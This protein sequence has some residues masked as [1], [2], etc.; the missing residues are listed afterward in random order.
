[1]QMAEGDVPQD[2]TIA[3]GNRTEGLVVVADVAAG[4]TYASYQNAIPVIRSILVENSSGL[5][6]ETCRLELTS[7]PAFLRPKTWTIDRLAPGDSLT[8]SD[9]KVELDAGYLAGL[10]EAERGEITL[11]LVT[12]GEV[13]HEQRI[14]V[15]LVARDEW[16]GVADMAQLL[17]AFVMPNDPAVAAILRAAADRLAAHGHQ[18][19]LDGYQSGSPQRAFL[20]AAAVYSAIAG[21]GLH[22][23]EPPA[24]FERRGQKVRR[25]GTILDERLA[26]CLDTTLL[27]AAALEAAGLNP[28]VL[29]FEGHAAVGVWLAKRTFPSA[30]EPDAMEV[31]K[32]LALRE[33]IVFETT[34][35]THRPA[36]T[37]EAAQQ[38]LDRRIGDDDA[39]AFLAAIDVRRARS[40][41]ITPLASHAP[42]Q[43]GA[44]DD[45]APVA[46][47]PLPA[48]P[49]F[50]DLPAEPAE[51]KPTT[52]AGR[53]DRW[54]KKLLDL[55]L[56]NRLLN[57][58]DS[59]KSIPFLCTDVG[60]LEDRLAK[61][62]AIRVISLPEQNPLGERDP[63][64][65]RD[66]HGRDLQRGFV[67]EALQRDELPSPLEPRQLEARL[68]ELH[69]QVRNDFAEGGANTLFLAVGFLRWK[70]KP[71]DERSY[72]APLLL[73]PVKLERRSA[74]SRFTIRFHEDEPRFNATLLQFLDREFDLKLTS[75]GGEL[76]TDDNGVDVPKLLGQVRQAIRDV[77]GME[78][79][80]ETALSTFSFAKFLMWKDLVERTDALRQNRV[81]RHLIDTP[82]QAFA[83]PEGAAPFREGYEIDRAYAP[84]DIICL[85]PSDSSQTAASLAAA[86]GRDFVIVG[87]PG[88]GKS[89][90][91]ANMIANCLGVGKTVL[92]VAEKTAALDVVNR[93]LREHGLG[94]QC[95]ELH[96]NKADRKHFL[97]QLKAA[98]E[99]G[100]T[101]DASAWVA[102][103]ERLR[104]RRD[105]LNAYVEALH[106]RYPNGW[107][108][109]L[110]LGR[111][112]KDAGQ[113][114]PQLGW[115]DGRA[116][117]EA[118]LRELEDLAAELGLVF[119]SVD[120]QPALDLVDQEEW[121][122]SW[123]EALLGAAQSL[124]NAADLLA[125]AAE[126]L[127]GVLGLTPQDR[128]APV[129][130]AALAGLAEALAAARGRDISVA[131]NRDFATSAAE[132]AELES[133]IGV[134]RAT[135]R[136]LAAGYGIAAVRAL[137]IDALE[138][139]WRAANDSFWPMSIFARR[140]ARQLLQAEAA[141]GEVDPDRDLPL[142]RRM[143][144]CLAAI[145]A[146]PLGTKP[147]PIRGL[148]T[149]IAAVAAL[150]ALAEG[151]RTALRAPGWGQEGVGA[152]IRA[153]A[154]CLPG[155]AEPDRVRAAGDRLLACLRG[156]E[157]ASRGFGDLAG[158]EVAACATGAE[159]A[160][161]G[162]TL[163]ELIAARALLRDWTAWCRVR[164]AALGR[165]LG[166]LVDA[167][168]DGTI[169]PDAARAAFRLGYA[170]WWLPQ[171][172]DGDPVLRDFR[173]F[174]HENAIKDFRE[175]DDLVRTHATGRVLSA[176]AHG[177]PPVQGVPRNSEL[178]LLR[179]QMELQR[180]SQTI[181]DMIGRM[182]QSFP[183]L[184]PCMLM[185]PL[186]IAQYLPSNQAL[187]DVVIFDEASQITTWDAVGAIA[188][189]RQ[190]II[191]GDP[192]QLPPTNFFGRNE[193]EG[194][195]VADHEKDLESI[196][197]EA[198]ASG[199]P[200]RDLRW[201][202]RS[203][204]E[205]LI[206]FSNH[207][208]Y[209]NRL[210]TFPSPAVDDKAVFLR[211][212]A[213]GVYD[214]GKSR[215]NR[216]EAEAV[217]REAVTRMKGWLALP[218]KSRP[219][220]GVITFNSQ[221][222]SLILDLLDAARR[223]DPALEWFFAEERIEPAIV[224]NL[225]NVQGDERDVILF[226][227]TFAKDAAG[228]L[229]MDF[230]ALNRSGGE[231]RL[232]VAVTRARQELLVFSGITADLIDPSRT[233]AV[234]VRHLKTFLDYAERG[235]IALPAEDRGSVGGFESPFEEAVAAE[236]ARRGWDVVPQ[237]G[238]SGFRV[239]LG[240]RHPDLP[241]AYLAGI[242]CDGATYHGSATARDR[243][244]VREQVLRG[245]GW[246]ILRV[247]STDWWFDAIGCAARLHAGLDALLAE[248]RA[249]RDAEQTNIEVHWDMG[250]EVED[251]PEIRDE[252]AIVPV[253]EA[254][255]PAVVAAAER[256]AIEGPGAP[257][258]AQLRAAPSAPAPVGEDAAQLYR[259][260]DLSGFAADPDAF[261]ELRY[262][263]ILQAMI[264]AVME[265]ESPLRTDV[266][267]QRIS[268]VHGWLR[269]GGR[270]R[271]RIEL[272]LKT[273]DRTQE[274][275]GEF[276]WK[277]GSV[278]DIAAYRPPATEEARRPVADIPL[279]E[280]AAVALSHPGL[281]DQ[282]DPARELARLLGVERLAAVSRARL[283]E[284]IDR[285]RRHAATTEAP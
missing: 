61:G 225:E 129:S 4:F 114:A 255:P 44:T 284:A 146:S 84:A 236:L 5:T 283:D 19:A 227:I 91:I 113:P 18:S 63:A 126:G 197:D 232:N 24:S 3:A 279:A 278:S 204:S 8:L 33:L 78:V 136:G 214:R 192:K 268:R 181:R 89:Q 235:A 154:P 187:F 38:A 257:A 265:T 47:L 234:A 98:W 272:H 41:G 229:A 161:L 17:P 157:A 179:H 141:R 285:A 184:A 176:I 99:N 108:P 178:G 133:S 203:R 132:L 26:T 198:K 202:Y 170:R 72:R 245:L 250:H 206:A 27:F 222:Q 182:P 221:Q 40:G 43:G 119:A 87:P 249:R 139:E 169:R 166:G 217:A 49:G 115:P 282:S 69:R 59:K 124:K 93:R 74:S 50:D 76:P 14:A 153:V 281:L 164:N 37:L 277:P 58:P 261:H 45:A 29:L 2:E 88:T 233:K 32:A 260:T 7:S 163:G 13:L 177:L 208:Y 92:F 70:K 193:E 180:P 148:D 258:E 80:D 211:K 145:D 36:M 94:D 6:I 97:A 28:V 65:Y 241:G 52:A 60:F 247:W 120:R 218:E 123:Q 243:D 85:L 175:I 231:R 55:T 251:I 201:H 100:G 121:S 270:I 171:V 105:Q 21:L 185:S 122:S 230:G 246:N 135:E 212:V 46:E 242:E 158:R 165:H 79:V 280:L 23:A 9:R 106:R 62:A 237:I 31:R 22:Y 256:V 219:T 168:G 57:F 156:F 240:V 213:N 134:Y 173:R 15:R 35:V 30:I 1:M 107:T 66:V 48:A 262:R 244:K 86:E 20:I 140:K 172:L 238:I 39:R 25:P 252:D 11:R 111:A 216:I 199:I 83:G 220:L 144:D 205:S 10:N 267:A 266:L 195:E 276:V 12:A 125:G 128:A 223:D 16:G 112:L 137:D 190:T 77:P 155:S 186:S 194:D 224:K 167:L 239:D 118:A 248:S 271:E 196:L 81:V 189:A 209:E 68:V 210:V 101:G 150:L 103:N 102:V 64:L 253:A 131:F 117:D 263:N 110:A 152:V 138:A 275:S 215:T 147:L 42:A 273:L 73:V 188:R 109:Y 200:V 104:L 228:K 95:I 162:E 116:P 34:G 71:A 149:D 254:P 127:L 67:A 151:L 142:L 160:A 53:I 96:S 51:V 183:K 54:Q 174:Q 143:K 226:S 269:T 207:H 159:A 56:R 191:V 75:L 130:L 274:S 90:T 259:I 82:E 264:D